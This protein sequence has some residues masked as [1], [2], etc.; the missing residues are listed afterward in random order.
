MAL[1]VARSP[2][3]ATKSKPIKVLFKLVSLVEVETIDE[4]NGVK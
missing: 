2:K 4:L 3:L 1:E